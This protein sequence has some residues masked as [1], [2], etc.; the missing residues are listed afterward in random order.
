MHSIGIR[1]YYLHHP[2]QA[3]GS[4]HFFLPLEEGRQLYAHLRDDLSSWL[5]PHYVI[6]IPGGHG[7]VNAFNPESL[8]FSGTW[9]DRFGKT[10]DK[11]TPSH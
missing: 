1:P 5:L 4:M 9:I 3:K 7:K 2:D 8:E 11:P 10:I 6:D